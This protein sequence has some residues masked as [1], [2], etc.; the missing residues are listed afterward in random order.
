MRRKYVCLKDISIVIRNVWPLKTN[1]KPCS[2]LGN[3]YG[4]YNGSDMISV[5]RLTKALF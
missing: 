2:C 4:S 3:K 1:G 5:S